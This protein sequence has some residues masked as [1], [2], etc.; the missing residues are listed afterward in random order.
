MSAS[1]T[2]DVF[3]RGKGPTFLCL[4]LLLLLGQ[5][6]DVREWG[7]Y[8][9]YLFSY[10]YI[11]RNRGCLCAVCP[12]QRANGSA[13]IAGTAVQ[14]SSVL[15]GLGNTLPEFVLFSGGQFCSLSLTSHYVELGLHFGD[16]IQVPGKATTRK[17]NI[18]SW[19]ADS[20]SGNVLTPV[21]GPRCGNQVCDCQH[22]R[23]PEDNW[24]TDSQ[25]AAS[26][27]HVFGTGR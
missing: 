21:A 27:K 9:Y 6:Q 24:N 5:S 1:L 14:A 7:G 26:E 13:L 4:L 12:G 2:L 20:W 25:G 15:T 16:C 23:L 10:L 19:H 18:H 22:L 8:Y 3:R 17:P 11:L